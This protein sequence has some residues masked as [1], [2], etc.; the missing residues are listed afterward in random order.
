MLGARGYRILIVSLTGSG[1]DF[2]DMCM[3][4]SVKRLPGRTNLKRG[5]AALVN[6]EW[7]LPVGGPDNNRSGDKAVWL[8]ACL[9]LSPLI[10]IV[11]RLPHFAE[12]RLQL[13]QPS[14]VDWRPLAL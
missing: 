5:K 13:P 10:A 8:A 9:P 2:R 12:I 3:G 11:A 1:T 14:N 7:T 4:G 6:D